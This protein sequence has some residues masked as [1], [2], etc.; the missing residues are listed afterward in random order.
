P[1]MD[2]FSLTAAVRRRETDTGRRLPVIAMTAHAMTGV[3]EQCLAADM[4]DYVSKPIRDEDL[5]A[6]L[7]R[8]VPGAGV[9][10]TD[11]GDTFGSGAQE[12]GAFTLSVAFD[13][14][15]VLARVGGNR[16]TLR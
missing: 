2:G 16:E 8:A 12:T 9:G 4:D 10:S 3:R 13:E 6:A 7:R 1:D 14:A 5:L 11:A 15:A